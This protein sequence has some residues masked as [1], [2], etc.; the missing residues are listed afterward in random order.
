MNRASS[1]L[2]IHQIRVKVEQAQSE[3]KKL[4]LQLA[5]CGWYVFPCNLDK[6][7]KLKWKDRATVDQVQIRGWWAR[8]PASLIGIYCQRSGFFAVDIDVKNGHNGFA[9]WTNL[10]NSHGRGYHPV[11]G[12]AQDTPSG[13]AHLLFTLP[14]DIAI[15]NNSGKLGDG[16]DL[17][18]NGYICSG[19]AYHWQP[20]HGPDMQLTPAPVWLLDLIQEMNHGSSRMH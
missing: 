12:P 7:P 15:P 6:T 17:R 3:T 2:S 18:S 16:L 13:G 9:S 5:D 14:A 10:I 19:G 4:A 20:G 11:V 1:I 8:W